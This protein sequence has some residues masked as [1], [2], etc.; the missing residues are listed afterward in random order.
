MMIMRKTLISCFAVFLS[1]SM[2]LTTSA[3]ELGR[4]FFTPKERAALD[5]PPKAVTETPSEEIKPKP[6]P[7]SKMTGYV[8]RSD[9]P[10]TV[11]KNG[12]P[13]YDEDGDELK[14]SAVQ[15]SRKITVKR[16][17]ERSEKK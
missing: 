12:K 5:Q 8:T 7:R 13:K 17:G 2:P 4:L 16:S 1:L 10:V 6:T 14:P 15:T 3:E 11:W 9:G